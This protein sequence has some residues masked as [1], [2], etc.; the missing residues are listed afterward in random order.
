MLSYADHIRW[1]FAD[2]GQAP[3]DYKAMQAESPW[4]TAGDMQWLGIGGNEASGPPQ[5]RGDGRIDAWQKRAAKHRE[6][7]LMC[8]ACERQWSADEQ[9]CLAQALRRI[10]L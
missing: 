3:P 2:L 9:V 5:A 10:G 6:Y 8:R 7:V 1:M 4:L